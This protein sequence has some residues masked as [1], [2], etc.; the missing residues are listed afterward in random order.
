M[1]AILLTLFLAIPAWALTDINGKEV[2]APGADGKPLL[3]YYVMTDCPISNQFAPEMNRICSEYGKQGVN[4]YLAYVDPDLSSDTI[5]GH[6]KDYSHSIKAINDADH[7]LVKLAEAEVTPEAALFDGAGKLA[8]R[9]R[10]NNFY[11]KLGTPR[12]QATQH[13]LRD[14]L[15]A[16]LAGKAV[17]N[18]RTQAIGCFIPDLEAIRSSR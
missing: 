18:P 11:A 17:E 13:D 15:D 6:L 5:R 16:V 8:Y 2:S 3:I 14:A 12:R 1:R 9:G 4:C 10:L 7:E